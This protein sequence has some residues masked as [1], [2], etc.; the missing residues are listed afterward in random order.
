MK[1]QFLLALLLSVCAIGQIPAPSPTPAVALPP[2][3]TLVFDDE[4]QQ[5]S[6]FWN[7]AVIST[8]SLKPFPG[9]PRYLAHTPTNEDFSNFA[10]PSSDGW[11]FTADA[12]AVFGGKTTFPAPNNGVLTILGANVNGA[13]YG[14]LLSTADTQGGGFSCINGYWEAKIWL[15]PNPP[16]STIPRGD[17]GAPGLW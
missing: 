12:A 4:F 3:Y 15:P 1:T 17:Y 10:D 11:P 16:G 2:G 13:P 9:L 6:S 14:G 7:T 5:G 8:G